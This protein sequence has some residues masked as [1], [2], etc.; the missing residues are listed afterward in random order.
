LKTGIGAIV[1]A[2]ANDADFSLSYGVNDIVY[3]LMS[4]FEGTARE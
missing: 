1:F 4:W 2:N 3:H